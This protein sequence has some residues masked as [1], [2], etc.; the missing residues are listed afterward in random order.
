MEN[1]AKQIYLDLDIRK[2]G[3]TQNVCAYVFIFAV[4]FIH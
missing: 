1:I 3:S 2:H 4:R